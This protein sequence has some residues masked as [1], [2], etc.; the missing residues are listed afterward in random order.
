MACG[1]PT[2]D[3]ATPGNELNY[4]NRTDVAFLADID[5]DVMADQICTLLADEHQLRAR[6]EAGLA[7]V[8]KMPSEEETARRIERLIL[9]RVV[10]KAPV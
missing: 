9:R 7:L 6:S 2:V 8:A 4:G 1:L 3:L 10:F 5:P